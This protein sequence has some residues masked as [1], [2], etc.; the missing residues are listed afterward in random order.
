MNLILNPGSSQIYRDGFIPVRTRK[1]TTKVYLIEILYIE[2]ERRVVKIYTE[3]RDYR[4]YGK[5]DEVVK[6]LDGNFYRSHKSCVINLGKID[7]MEDGLVYFPG[8]QSV[9]IGENNYRITKYRY[10]EYLERIAGRMEGPAEKV[11]ETEE[12]FG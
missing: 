1:E 5:L 2:T 12:K 4:F 3:Q 9:R 8:G 7:R 10:Y 6:Y 11:S